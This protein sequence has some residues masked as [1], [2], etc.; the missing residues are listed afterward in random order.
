MVFGCV[1]QLGQLGHALWCPVAPRAGAAPCSLQPHS[2]A[3]LPPSHLFHL[4]CGCV[5]IALILLDHLPQDPAAAWRACAAVSLVVSLGPR[6][7]QEARCSLG[8]RG[9]CSS[10]AGGIPPE[11]VAAWGPIVFPPCRR[12]HA[13]S[14]LKRHFP[15]SVKF[16][17]N[18]N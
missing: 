10:D 1:S 3:H 7:Q 5:F 9:C 12:T 15:T 17:L 16:F 8:C 4:V 11:W 2:L 14:P 13:K 6:T 18:H